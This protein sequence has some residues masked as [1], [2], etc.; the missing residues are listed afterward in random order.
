MGSHRNHLCYVFPPLSSHEEVY[1]SSCLTQYLDEMFVKGSDGLAFV[2]SQTGTF[3]GDSA[4]EN[5]TGN[6]DT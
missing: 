1:F 4:T 3:G 6:S 2:P 5:L